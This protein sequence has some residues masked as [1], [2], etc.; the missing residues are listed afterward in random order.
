MRSVV[1]CGSMR[2]SEEIDQFAERLM[3]LGVPLVLTPDFKDTKKDFRELPERE[4]LASI[5]YRK[6]VPEFVLRHL[7]RIRKADICFVYNKGGYLGVNTTI[8]VGFAHGRDMVIYALER[9]GPI[10]NGGEICREIL[11][12][13]IISTPES[14]VE[15]LKLTY[16]DAEPKLHRKGK[17]KTYVRSKRKS[18][19]MP[20]R[21]RGR[22]SAPR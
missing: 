14:L 13:D 8:E 19:S 11:F 22:A 21:K 16:R 6:Q 20:V 17:T 3:R 4:R 1:I 12:T 10:E 18:Q 9:E 7:D 5:P 2:F 15:R